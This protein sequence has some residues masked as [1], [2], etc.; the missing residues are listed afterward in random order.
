MSRISQ[1]C[2]LA[3]AAWVAVC[4]LSHAQDAFSSLPSGDGLALKMEGLNDRY[5]MYVEHGSVERTPPI[6]NFWTLQVGPE[7]V[8]D[9]SNWRVMSINCDSW[10]WAGT[11]NFAV[12]TDG[13]LFGTSGED[14]DQYTPITED[15]MNESIAQVMCE[16][17]DFELGQPQVSS[18]DQAV[19]QAHS[20]LKTRF[21]VE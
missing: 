13:K 18:F 19:A 17:K 6:V 16:G 11:R 21:G 9:Y 2:V 20:V 15:S 3:A 4:P 1:F 10:S 12:K 14:V 5:A 8:V 7:S